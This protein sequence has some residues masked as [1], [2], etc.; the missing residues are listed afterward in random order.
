MKK[1]GKSKVTVA[2]FLTTPSPRSSPPDGSPKLAIF[3]RTASTSKNVKRA[4]V[5]LTKSQPLK[6]LSSISDLKDLAS[7][8][9]DELKRQ[10]DRSHSEILKDLEASQSRLHKRFKVLFVLFAQPLWLVV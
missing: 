6:A 2:E 9:V 1:R 8:R 5:G 7:S 3:T 10:I 4:T